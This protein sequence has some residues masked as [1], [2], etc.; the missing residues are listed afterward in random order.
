MNWTHKLYIIT[1]CSVLVT[2]LTAVTTCLTKLRKENR[3]PLAHSLRAH[4]TVWRAGQQ[5][6]EAAGYAALT[7][8]GQ[9]RQTLQLCSPLSFVTVWY[10]SP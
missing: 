10:F 3:F 7:S 9:E 1:C 6:C 5:E 8:K 4:S 2:L